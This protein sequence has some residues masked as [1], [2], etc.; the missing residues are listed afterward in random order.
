MAKVTYD[1]EAMGHLAKKPTT[2]GTN[3]KELMSWD[4]MV[5]NSIG[6]TSAT[7][8]ASSQLSRW[9]FGL[10]RRLARAICGGRLIEPL[11]ED[12]DTV[13]F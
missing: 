1:Q 3:Y 9:A 11:V 6:L 12:L 4:G 5:A 7:A 2:S 10:R 13:V 8:L